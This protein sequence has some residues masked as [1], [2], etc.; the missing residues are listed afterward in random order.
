M[1]AIQYTMVLKAR[2]LNDKFVISLSP[3]DSLEPRKLVPRWF[4]S[5]NNSRC[6]KIIARFLEYFYDL[7][8]SFLTVAQL[9]EQFNIIICGV[10]ACVIY[11]CF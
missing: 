11:H 9:Q 1:A 8:R 2:Y 4:D 3:L 6:T 5:V 7:R 10:W